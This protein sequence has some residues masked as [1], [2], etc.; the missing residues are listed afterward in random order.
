MEELSPT[1]WEKHTGKKIPTAEDIFS[2]LEL[3]E[4]W[5]DGTTFDFTLPD[6]ITDYVINV[7]FDDSGEIEEIN[8]ES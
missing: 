4:A 1:Y 5:E 2:I 6:E 8:M 7:S 3:S